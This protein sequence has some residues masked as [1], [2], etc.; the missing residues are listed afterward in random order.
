MI[1]LLLSLAH[2]ELPLPVYPECGTPERPDLCPEELGQS[3]H[4]ISYIPDNARESVRVAELE[5][6]SGNQVDQAWSLSTGRF[7]TLV[8][9][10]D[11]GVNWGRKDLAQKYYLNAAELPYP[12][13]AD[14]NSYNRHDANEDGIFNVKDYEN[15]PRV[16]I[17]SGI[18]GSPERL[19]P[20][21]LIAVFSDGIDD[22]GNGYTDDISGWDF[23]EHD[24]DAYHQKSNE[25]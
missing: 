13:D 22:D 21:D 8:A 18:N 1:G 15:D 7:D 23:F 5:L 6:G 19:D 24:N 16:S 9:V 11:T 12:Q 4:L 3:W 17:D 2:A 25:G 14:G 20:S 10:M